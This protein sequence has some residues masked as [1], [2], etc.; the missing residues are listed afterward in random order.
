MFNLDSAKTTCV[1]IITDGDTCP[2]SLYLYTWHLVLELNSNLNHNPPIQ[3][4]SNIYVDHLN[5]SLP[6]KGIIELL[7]CYGHNDNDQPIVGIPNPNI[8]SNSGCSH[9]Y[10]I[11]YNMQLPSMGVIVLHIT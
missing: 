8:P 7:T 10:N 6:I 3:S 11:Q 5:Q 4:N 1:L 9:S 2:K